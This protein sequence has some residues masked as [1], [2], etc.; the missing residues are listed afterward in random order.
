MI[1]SYFKTMFVLL[2]ALLVSIKA[3]AQISISYDY[4]RD[5]RLLVENTEIVIDGVTYEIHLGDIQVSFLVDG[6]TPKQYT[7]GGGY[8]RATSYD[9]DLA[10]NV[11]LLK[12]FVVNSNTPGNYRGFLTISADAP[13]VFPPEVSNVMNVTFYAANMFEGKKKLESI[14]IPD[15]F[16]EIPFRFFYECISLKSVQMPNTINSIDDAAFYG[17]S[18]LTGTLTLPEGLKSIG[19]AAFTSC[20][21]LTG[22]LTF[23]DGLE[24][25]G[26]SAFYQCSGFTGNLTIPHGVTSIN[27][28]AFLGC[29]G[30]T[31]C[32]T[33]P[34]GVTAIGV[35]AFNGCSGFT[36]N[37][38]IPEGVTSIG[39][40]AFYGCSGFTGSL[41]IPEGVTSIGEGAFYG[42]SGFS[43]SLTLPEGVTSIGDYA[44]SDCSGLTGSLTIPEGVTS[45]GDYA[46]SDC[47]GLTGSLTIPEGVT[48][49]GDYAFSDCSGLTGNLII[50][51]GVTSIGESSFYQCRGLTG[52][53][54]IPEGVTY[55]G[56]SAFSG[57][58]SLT[59]SLTIPKGVTS[60]SGY[61]FAY[62]SGFTGSLTIP[63]GVTSIGEK[64]FSQCRGLTG[65]L[66]LPEGL[67]S[68]GIQAFSLCYGFTGSLIIPEGVTSIGD[69]AFFDC[70]G[71]TG[72]LTIPEGVTS[73]GEGAFSRCSGIRKIISGIT[74]PFECTPFDYW[75]SPF[76]YDNV[77]LIVPRG[78]REAYLSTSDWNKFAIYE[79]ETISETSTAEPVNISDVN[80]LVELNIK[81]NEWSTICLPFAMT[82]Q[83][84]KDAFGDDVEL[85]DFT[86]WQ[87]TKN[88]LGNVT[89]ISVNFSSVAFIEANHPYLIKVSADVE[90]FLVE[91]V[92]ISVAAN[93][94]KQVGT[95]EEDYGRFVGTYVADTEIPENGMFLSGNKFCYSKGQTKTKAFRGYF[96]FADVLSDVDASGAPNIAITVDDTAAR[97][98]DVSRDVENNTYYTLQG[99]KTNNPQKGV[100][101]V[102]GKKIIVR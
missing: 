8:A 68:I 47:S 75:T 67:K 31:G 41:T 73:I 98:V 62:C 85:A 89:G 59:G 100:F 92:D 72:S 79:A 101:I 27:E 13:V 12:E 80:V 40:G 11:T 50:P 34:A 60:I 45:I 71:F 7:I 66:T 38:T 52:S 33:I 102:N 20:S 42:C 14:T 88:A 16:K 3:G 90:N 25:I 84:V 65:S 91:D 49:I 18:G 58:S 48:S 26:S 37:L 63:E 69:Y 5:P 97:I 96:E 30:F 21:G 28:N 36:G 1:T 87:S 2:A 17:C 44:F 83:Q 39:E 4:D 70:S 35:W 82:E 23:P 55:I 81:A 51:E 64:A 29:S 10:S 9:E 19:D 74:V 61:A 86:S 76:N 93:P 22:S 94:M 77:K 46:F 95:N 54:T 32:L 99:A 24:S 57:C 43:G 53:L 56:R 6:K 78:T 15:N